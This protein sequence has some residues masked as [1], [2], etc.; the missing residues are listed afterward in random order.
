M[1]TSRQES[2]A[3]TCLIKNQLARFAEVVSLIQNFSQ[4]TPD[5][6]TPIRVQR[7]VFPPKPL[8]NA[9]EMVF[10]PLELPFLTLFNEVFT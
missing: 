5:H 9:F 10:D 8:E 3:L 6:Q 4:I 2:I 1:M 7:A